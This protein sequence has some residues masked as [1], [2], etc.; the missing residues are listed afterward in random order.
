MPFVDLHCDTIARLLACRR[1]G[2]PGQLR[3][4]EGAHVTLKTPAERI[5][6]PELCPVCQFAGRRRPWGRGRCRGPLPPVHGLPGGVAVGGGLTLADLYWTEM[7]ANEDLAV[8]VRSFQEMERPGRR[9]DCLPADRGGGGR[10]PGVPSAAADPLPAGVDA[11]PHL[12]YP[13][14][15]GR[16]NGQPGGLTRRGSS[17]WRRW[18]TWG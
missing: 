16:P 2:L 17:S 1:A 7:E 14:E 4:G 10:L 13:N 18:R 8:P 12:N 5:P 15:L 6:A 3:T 9:K 11:H